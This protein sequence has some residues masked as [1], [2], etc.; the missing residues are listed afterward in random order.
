MNHGFIQSLVAFVNLDVNVQKRLLYI[1]NILE[2]GTEHSR[3]LICH[4]YLRTMQSYI[5]YCIRILV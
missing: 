5:K 2:E 4:Y 1:C 3:M